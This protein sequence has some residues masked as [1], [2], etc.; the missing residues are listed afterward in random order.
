MNTVFYITLHQQ[1]EKTMNT[2]IELMQEAL[3]QI[4]DFGLQNAD[5]Q[6][7]DIIRMG[8]TDLTTEI[9]IKVKLSKHT[10]EVLAGQFGQVKYREID[11]V[12]C[13]S[14]RTM[15]MMSGGHSIYITLI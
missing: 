1:N 6:I 8:S 5:I 4:R 2:K 9:D 11:G 12:R 15:W 7:R 14:L 13:L 3:L 10:M